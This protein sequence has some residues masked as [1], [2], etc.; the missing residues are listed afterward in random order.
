VSVCISAVCMSVYCPM[1]TNKVTT[2]SKQIILIH[3]FDLKNSDETHIKFNPNPPFH[4]TI[5]VKLNTHTSTKVH[6]DPWSCHVD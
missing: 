5:I 1:T 4:S 2:I 6:S 3:E